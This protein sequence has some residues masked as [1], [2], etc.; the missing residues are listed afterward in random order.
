MKRP[1]VQSEEAQEQA[2]TCEEKQTLEEFLRGLV[3][4]E[5]HEFV[6]LWLKA[7]KGHQIVTLEALRRLAADVGWE[8]F[9]AELRTSGHHMLAANLNRWKDSL[10]QEAPAAQPPGE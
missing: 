5:E 4:E 1:K 8:D 3:A 6:V 2:G 9:L 10:P 7:L